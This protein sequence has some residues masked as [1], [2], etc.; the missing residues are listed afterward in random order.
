[1][2]TDEQISVYNALKGVTINAAYQ[3]FE[4]HLKGS[5]K[6]EKSDLNLDVVL[7]RCNRGNSSD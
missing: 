3:Y 7:P 4:E 5:I 6:K 1:M 2:G